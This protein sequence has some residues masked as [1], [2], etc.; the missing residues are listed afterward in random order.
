[1]GAGQGCWASARAALRRRETDPTF[2]SGASQSAP[3]VLI[4][5]GSDAWKTG[6]C[7]PE[8]GST[9][10]QASRQEAAGRYRKWDEEQSKKGDWKYID[11]SIPRWQDDNGP[12]W[13]GIDLRL[14][15]TRPE[16]G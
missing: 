11:S 9:P 3:Q 16:L 15:G 7:D 10:E 12:S 5:G 8:E 6:F 14:L 1:M 2:V 4:K 13:N